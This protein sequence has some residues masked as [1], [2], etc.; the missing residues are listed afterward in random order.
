M[1]LARGLDYY[2]G[3]VFE[4]FAEGLGISVGGGGRYDNLIGLFG[5]PKTP[6]VGISFGIDRLLDLL[7]EKIEIKKGTK[8]FVAAVGKEL[9]PAALG[10]TQKIRALGINAAM[11][12]NARGISKNLD[13]ANKLGI[14]FVVI[15]GEKELKKKEFTLK[16]MKTGKERKVKV[17]DL[18]KLVKLVEQKQG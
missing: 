18:K 13:Y 10:L 9:Q 15:L 17:A 2:T 12:L 1:C 4:I 3:N 5:A 16:E 8:V 14:P 6:A 7:E 11:D